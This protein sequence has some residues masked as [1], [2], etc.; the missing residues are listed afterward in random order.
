VYYLILNDTMEDEVT[1]EVVGPFASY[2]DAYGFIAKHPNAVVYPD[3]HPHYPGAVI[4][5]PGDGGYASVMVVGPGTTMA[6]PEEKLAEWREL[7][8]EDSDVEPVEHVVQP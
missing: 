2:A 4:I 3:D 7:Y 5:R 6:A 1:T 8:G